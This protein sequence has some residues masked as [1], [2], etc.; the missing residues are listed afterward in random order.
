MHRRKFLLESLVNISFNLIEKSGGLNALIVRCGQLS[1]TVLEVCEL[2]GA[3]AVYTH[4]DIDFLALSTHH[5]L[6]LTM[7]KHDIVM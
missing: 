7:Q 1:K 6:K 2:T 5:E 4:V 3:S